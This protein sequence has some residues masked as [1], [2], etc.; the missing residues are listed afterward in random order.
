MNKLFYMAAYCYLEIQ[1]EYLRLRKDMFI[2][3][4]NAGHT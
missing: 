2:K 3:L 1:L 4:Y